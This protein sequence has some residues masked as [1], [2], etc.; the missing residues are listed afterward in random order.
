ML[1]VANLKGAIQD[2]EIRAYGVQPASWWCDRAANLRASTV[3]DVVNSCLRPVCFVTHAVQ[4]C[5]TFHPEGAEWAEPEPVL[6]SEGFLGNTAGQ[7]TQ[8]ATL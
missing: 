4:V 8:L 1:L 5:L 2:V 7:C 6:V 3:A